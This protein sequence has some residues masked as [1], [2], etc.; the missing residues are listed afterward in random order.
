MIQD[1]TTVAVN[2]TNAMIGRSR[3][4]VGLLGAG[5]IIESHAKALLSLPTVN[6]YAVC[7]ISKARAASGRFGIPNVF[8]SLEEMLVSP[9]ESIHILL[10][11][12]AHEEAA[13]R[14]LKAGKHV[15]L[16][17]PM[18]LSSFGCA[19]LVGVAKSKEVKLGVSHNFLFSSAYEAIRSSIKDGGVGKIDRVT[20]NWLY[21][22]GLIRYGPYDNWMLQSPANLIFELAPHAVAYVLDIL[23][24]L[25][26][27]CGRA[28]DPID[29]PGGLRV[30]R[31]WTMIG[32]R[33]RSSCVIN[34]S[35]NPGQDDRSLHIR[36]S[37]AVARLD[38]SRGIAWIERSQ[39]GNPI[40]DLLG[41]GRSLG[42]AILSASR[43]GFIK[44]LSGSLIKSP[45][46]SPY[47]ESI[48]RS[49]EA[50]YAS[51]GPD[52][53]PRLDGNFGVEVIRLCE[54]FAAATDGMDVP[55]H[56]Q[57]AVSPGRAADVLV[58]GGS[59]FIGKRLVSNLV[60]AGYT[61]RV[62]SRNRESALHE[63]GDIPVDIVQGAYGDSLLLDAIFPGIK[64][65]YHFAKA[66]GAQ[67]SDYL[68]A[69][70]EP[71]EALA[72][73][74]LRHG[75]RRL[76]STGTIDSYS[77]SNPSNTIN[78]DTK[79]DPGIRFRN[80]YARSKAVCE[81]LLMHE[82]REHG[83]PVIILRP[84]IVIGKGSPCA[85]WGGGKFITPPLVQY[86]GKGYNKL[87]FVLVDD[88]AKALVL[89]G[90]REGIE[91]MT[92]LCTDRP[93]LSAKDYVEALERFSG[94]KIKHSSVPIWKHF[95]TDW[96]KE[97]VKHAI[98]H[99]NRRTSN[100]HDW[101]C[102][103][104]RSCYDS[105][106]SMELLDWH[107]CGDK[108]QMMSEGIQATVEEYYR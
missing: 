38:Y 95:A 5:Y 26:A 83:L 8:A 45:D 10:P 79:L 84:G 32:S 6:L 58:V 31:Q 21:E 29:L 34:L 2:G 105:S 23:G 7:D 85:H 20:V 101:A 35:V 54:S 49:I 66:S 102:R 107:P 65:V 73:P 103:A 25:D 94:I 96:I 52:L 63:L 106:T 44:Y 80:L 43:A 36:G 40:F 87:P 30:Y 17:K 99:P 82:Y 13:E 18:G 50:F 4:K 88:V 86:W 74:C 78:G 72:K 19:N 77:S 62:L 98:R 67:W 37:S 46:S 59:G 75:I 9:V 55:I 53:D 89:A 64:P 91:G 92:F 22:L 68:Y 97:F 60:T 41:H 42:K 14:C 76:V 1:N 39:T 108:A 90:T 104:H 57:K 51:A 16:E 48:H 70:I 24:P 33:G 3:I 81:E 12:Q 28:A 11:P 69:D 47:G 61:V 27:I 100:Y 71:T 56:A 15:L 93:M